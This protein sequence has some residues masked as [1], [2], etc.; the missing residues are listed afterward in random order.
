[1]RAR[2][3]CVVVPLLAVL[4]GTARAQEDTT[5]V[6]GDTTAAARA[7]PDSVPR[8]PAAVPQPEP[9][10]PQGPLAPGTRVT[11]TRDSLVWSGGQ[12][13]ADLLTRIPGVYVA[14]AGFWGQPEYVQYGGRGGAALEVYWDGV[15]MEPLGTDSL[16]IDAGRIPLS[17]LQR[18]DLEILPAALR[19]YLVSERYDGLTPRSTVRIATGAFETGAYAALFQHRWR[20]GIGLDVAG[21]VVDTQGASGPGRN[22]QTFDLWAKLSWQPTPTAGLTYQVRRHD[23]ER[24]VVNTTAGGVGVPAH[25]GVR[26][27]FLFTMLAGTPHGRGLRAEGGIGVSRWSPDSISTVPEQLVRQAHARVRYRAATWSAALEGRVSDTR[28]LGAVEARAGWVPTPGVIVSGRARWRRHTGNRTSR[29]ASGTLG[30]YHGPFSLVG[31]LAVS[32]ALQAPALPADTTIETLDHAVRFALDTGPLDAMVGL[33]RR[34]AYAPLP[35][36]DLA[37]VAGMAPV[38][39]ID[40]V[41]ADVRLWSSKALSFGARYSDPLDDSVADLQPP[42]QTRADITFRSKFWPTFRS[43]AFDLMARVS[44]ESWS[45]GTAGLTAAN[46]PIVLPGATF[47]TVFVQFQIVGFTMFWDFRN[48]RLT[49]AEFVPG[50]ASPRQAQ[51]FGITFEFF[52]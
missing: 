13:L 12:T 14:R 48:A 38:P 28:T 44:M 20:S 30:L 49:Q 33:V 5:A 16:F 24:P 43:G 45:T 1:M 3:W 47:Y 26:T 42:T 50:L 46:E 10:V 32:D 25:Q 36:P 34:D 29:D 8:R 51:T 31:E 17:Y 35:F 11:L 9:A 37:V 41:V 6:V 15:R 40:Y 23:Y 27:D 19:V 7:A 39:A 18:V 52:N 22:D 2:P 21:D 4:V